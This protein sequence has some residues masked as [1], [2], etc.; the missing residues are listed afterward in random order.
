MVVLGYDT[1]QPVTVDDMIHHSKAVRRGAPTRFIVADM[2]FG[3][4]ESGEDEALKNAFRLIK[5]TGKLHSKQR[6]WML[7]LICLI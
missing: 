5:E 4:Y 1:T 6:R 7:V 2:P 3:S